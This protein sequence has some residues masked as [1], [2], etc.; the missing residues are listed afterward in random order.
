MAAPHPP[1]P[2]KSHSCRSPKGP[3]FRARSGS[4]TGLSLQPARWDLPDS[5][6]PVCYWESYKSSRSSHFAVM[7][8]PHTLPQ[9]ALVKIPTRSLIP[10]TIRLGNRP[11]LAAS[12]MGFT[13]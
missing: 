9:I 4:V 3:S 13:G 7:A 12:K 2:P 6:T 1:P 11:I 5:R 8:A 10:S